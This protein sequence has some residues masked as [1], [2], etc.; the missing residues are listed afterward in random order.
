MYK[1]HL[2]LA[3]MGLI[4]FSACATAPTPTSS[5]LTAENAWGD[6][7]P[8]EARTISPEDFEAGIRDGSLVLEGPAASKLNQQKALAAFQSDLAAPQIFIFLQQPKHLD[9]IR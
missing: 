3:L 8:P 6:T 2:I 1:L 9:R 4:A 7:A 5:V